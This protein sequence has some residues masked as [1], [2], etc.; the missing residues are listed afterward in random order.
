MW[1]ENEEGFDCDADAL[2]GKLHPLARR[3]CLLTAGRASDGQ[4][5]AALARKV[6]TEAAGQNAFDFPEDDESG[7]S[8]LDTSDVDGDMHAMLVKELAT[9]LHEAGMGKGSRPYSATCLLASAARQVRAPTCR[10]N[11]GSGNALGTKLNLQ[12]YTAGAAP[13][14]CRCLGTRASL[15]ELRL[16]RAPRRVPGEHRGEEH[17][18]DGRRRSPSSRFRGTE[19]HPGR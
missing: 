6:V 7:E 16:W 2:N 8:A 19:L 11:G 17:S 18:G 13:D 14:C 4:S 5:L 3:L 15:Q 9:H 1:I 12:S 10:G